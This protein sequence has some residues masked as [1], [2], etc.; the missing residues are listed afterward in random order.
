MD[1]DSFFITACD[2]QIN[3]AET[4]NDLRI[5]IRIEASAPTA[6]RDNDIIHLE[7]YKSEVIKKFLHDGVIDYDHQSILG[8]TP[9]DKARAIIGEPTAFKIEKSTRAEVEVP[10][11]YGFLFKG[12]PYVDGAILPALKSKSKVWGASLGGSFH[13]S[14]VSIEKSEEGKSIRHIK[15]LK[16]IKHC[17]I[18]PLQKAIQQMTSV[19]L[20]AKSESFL[21]MLKALQVGY[22]TDMAGLSGGQAIQTQSLEGVIADR[23]FPKLLDIIKSL[24][25]A[26]AAGYRMS[27]EEHISPLI[28]DLPMEGQTSIINVLNKYK[29][30]I[31]KIL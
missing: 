13:K 4:E 5:P 20:M 30:K 29:T 9:V 19:E 27:V 21:E 11:V 7:A 23:M 31:M 26:K 28:K 18:T 10:V 16:N 24:R 3:K 17:A 15:D 8:L 1:H 2:I 6:D 25:I 12:N 22:A 14:G